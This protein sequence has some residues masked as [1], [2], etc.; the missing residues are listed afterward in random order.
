MSI[1]RGVGEICEHYGDPTPFIRPEGSVSEKWQHK[2]LV[3]IP[4][5]APLI[6]S[7]DPTPLTPPDTVGRMRCH[8]LVSKELEDILFLIHREGLWEHLSTFGGC[9]E[10]RKQKG[11]KKLSTHAWGIAVDFG[12][13]DNPLGAESKMHPQVVEIFKGYGWVWGGEFARRDAMH[14]QRASGY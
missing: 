12:V 9:Y 6:L 1:P 2:V 7:W 13:D 4:L 14:F 8:Y 5:P 11:G 10:W 3:T